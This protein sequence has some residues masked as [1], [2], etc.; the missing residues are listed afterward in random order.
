MI[1]KQKIVVTYL[2]L[3]HFAIKKELDE[4]YH[5][6]LKLLYF[7][8]WGNSGL[9]KLVLANLIKKTQKKDKYNFL[10]LVISWS[11]HIVLARNGEKE[12]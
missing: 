7:A 5:P 8:L 4:F 3:T 2:H 11:V 9:M 12:C 1:Q 6:T 10:Y